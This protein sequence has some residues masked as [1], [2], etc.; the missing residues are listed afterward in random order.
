MT[1]LRPGL[2]EWRRTRV[3]F[4]L[5]LA[6][7]V[8][9]A[10]AVAPRA[11]AGATL[12]VQSGFLAQYTAAAGEANNLRVEHPCL[13][14]GAFGCPQGRINFFDSAPIFIGTGCTRL[15]GGAQCTASR[16][17]VASGDLNDIVNASTSP[18]FVIVSGGPGDDQITGSARGEDSLGT[19]LSDSLSG[20][21]G[22]DT[23]DGG[24]RS[25][26]IVGGAGLDRII[27]RTGEDTI[28]A[29]DGVADQISCGDDLDQAELD[30]L[31]RIPADCEFVS[32]AAIDEGPNVV[33]STRALRVRGGKV[34]ATLSCPVAQ[35][36]NCNGRLELKGVGA[37]ARTLAHT[38]YRLANGRRRTVSLTISARRL[39]ALRRGRV[40]QVLLRARER[41]SRGRARTTI[42]RVP[43]RI[44]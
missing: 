19:S 31:D 14:G 34:R 11:A 3:A 16:A 24:P 36:R 17:R 23:L 10:S 20:E 30:L 5:G 6:A 28:L 25:D 4:V 29:R 8:L 21:D 27:G 39:A 15:T 13:G 41:D 7:T 44:R 18:N 43:L 32:Q 37:N 35:R 33:I 12:A 26:R 2:R 38:S 40:V 1:D 42:A 22:A 9:V